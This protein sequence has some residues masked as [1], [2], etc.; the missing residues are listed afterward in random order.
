MVNGQLS[1]RAIDLLMSSPVSRHWS[2]PDGRFS[3]SGCETRPLSVMPAQAGIQSA[4]APPLDSRFR[5]NDQTAP[6]NARLL[7]VFGERKVTY[8]LVS[9]KANLSEIL[10]VKEN[11]RF[12]N[13][14]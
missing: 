13:A 12:L 8:E 3:R 2:P 6:F 7:G 14:L 9:M 10:V 5:G 4:S 1:A 11:L